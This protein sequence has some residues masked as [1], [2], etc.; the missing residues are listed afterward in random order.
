MKHSEI[1]HHSQ[2][3][4]NDSQ[5]I[6]RLTV[7][8]DLYSC[9]TENRPHR[10]SKCALNGQKNCCNWRFYF[11]VHEVTLLPGHTRTSHP[12]ASNNQGAGHSNWP[13]TTSPFCALH[14]SNTGKSSISGLLLNIQHVPH[15]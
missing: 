13:N 12:S 1:L 15:L 5:I 14:L 10:S 7:C 2:I 3:A 11:N 8:F 9:K 4:L 6:L